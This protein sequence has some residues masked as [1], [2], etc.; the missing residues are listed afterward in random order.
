MHLC[1]AI[2]ARCLCS[3][4][5]SRS[6]S[7]TAVLLLTIPSARLE[8]AVKIAPVAKTDIA[9][10]DDTLLDTTVEVEATIKSI[11]KP[12][13]GDNGPVRIKLADDTG[14][15]T[16]VASPVVFDALLAQTPVAA[17]DLIQAS[18]RASKDGDQR[19]LTLQ[20]ATGL[21]ILSKVGAAEF[22]ADTASPSRADKSLIPLAAVDDSLKDKSITT[23]GTISDVREPRSERAPFVIT[24]VDGSAS[25]QMVLWPELYEQVK[26]H[27]RVGNTVQVTATVSDFRGTLQLRLRTT[28][29]I[30]TIA[31]A[32][33]LTESKGVGK[34]AGAKTTPTPAIKTDIGSITNDWTNRTVT[35]TGTIT[36]TDSVGKGQRLRI[37][38]ASGEISVILWESVLS[39][40][41]SADLLAGQAIIV[42][43][44]VNLY[45]GHLEVIASS[46]EAVKTA[47]N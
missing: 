7:F 38:D 8:A 31:G 26:Q 34:L 29:D 23:E 22:A 32:P 19:Q 3:A 9:A 33:S 2:C 39:K 24:L 37:R 45:R 41:A 16:L 35:I 43:G 20:T 25:I 4:W 6:L 5:S 10:I 12:N 1:H 14:S 30:Q 47:N 18:G 28:Q 17:G 46:P 13:E 40:L 11:T 15:I 21:R 42:T 44:P 27:L 36:A